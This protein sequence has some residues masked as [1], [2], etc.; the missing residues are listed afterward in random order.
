MRI[1]RSLTAGLCMAVAFSFVAVLPH[2]SARAQT[3]VNDKDVKAM[4]G[5][6]HQ[7]AKSF[8]PVFD[9]AIKKSAIRKTSQAKDNR[10]LAKEFEEQTGAM[11]RNFKKDSASSPE[12]QAVESTA[13]Q[14]DGVIYRL[15]L[16]SDVMDRWQKIRTELHEVMSAYN[17]PEH[18][19]E[20]AMAPQ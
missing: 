5:N 12:L 15:Q 8:R 17:M 9:S 6:L 20:P 4:M 7:D 3:R 18:Y 16:G 13:E 11:L 2:S 19:G 14:L 1:H 10:R